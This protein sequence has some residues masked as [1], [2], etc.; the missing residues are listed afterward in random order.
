MIEK[1]S[2]KY[3]HKIRQVCDPL[4]K[5]FGIN[6]FFYQ[7]VAS[8]GRY[9]II[10]TNPDF[11]HFY[12]DEKLH[13]CNP[14]IT[15]FHRLKSG[16]YPCDAVKD[17]QF[18]SSMEL[19]KKK[20]PCHHAMLLLEKKENYCEEYGFGIPVNRMDIQALVL[21]EMPL[22]RQFISYFRSELTRFIDEMEK[23]SVKLKMKS[24]ETFNPFQNI[25]LDDFQKKQFLT[26]ICPKNTL[27]F[28]VELSSREQECLKYYLGGLSMREIGKKL[29]LSPRTIESYIEH[30]KNKLHCHKKSDLFAVLKSLENKGM[31]A[32]IFKKDWL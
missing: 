6:Y 11:L 21:N 32:D 31:Y 10:G 7:R 4:F 2:G 22:Y 12:Y 29:F 17:R 27:P 9:Y 5:Y 8:D 19:S 16:I 18:Q 28:H 25:V 24:H 3:Q 13:E 20:Y 1:Y 26:S 14:F 30:A 23:N 15:Q